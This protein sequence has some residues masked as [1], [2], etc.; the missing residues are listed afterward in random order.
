MNTDPVLEALAELTTALDLRWDRDRMAFFHRALSRFSPPDAVA[1]IR[2]LSTTHEGRV[3]LPAIIRAIEG[4]RAKR[5]ISAA[6]HRMTCPH[7]GDTLSAT[8][9]EIDRHSIECQRKSS[10]QR[11]MGLRS[12]WEKY[13]RAI[14]GAHSH[15]GR[16]PAS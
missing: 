2:V 15:G 4:E 3:T 13:R 11:Q 8:C 1:G 12:A 16:F 10:E 7:C 5:M 9:S 6:S 14:Y